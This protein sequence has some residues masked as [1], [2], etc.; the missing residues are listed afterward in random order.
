MLVS[1]R[2]LA[3][4]VDL[5]GITPEQLGN[6]L[7]LSTCEVE[8]IEPFAPHLS[9]V[10]VGHVLE[11]VP[12]PDADKL[13]VCQVDV[14]SGEPLQIVCGAPNVGAGQR[15]AVATIGT[16][17]PGDFKI[18][19]SKIRGVESHGMICSVRELDLGDEHD[20]IWVL[21]EP[22]GEPLALGQSIANALGMGDWVI[23]IDNKSL[24]HRPDLWGHRGLAREVAAIYERPLKPIDLTL[25][26]LG[27]APAF[28]V[29]VA[30]AA[31]SRYIG[32]GIDGVQ[33]GKSPSWMRQLLLAVGQR[34]ID[35]FVDLS[36]FVMLDLGQ[37]NHAFD[38][39]ALDGGGIAVRKAKAG[40]TITTLDGELRKLETSDLL[41][42]SGDAPVA[43]A[44]I[45]GGEESKIQGGTSKLLLECAAFDA[46]TVRRTSSRLALRTDS[47]ARFEKSLDPTLP[48]KAA[49]HFARLLKEIQ[50]GVSFP[51]I[52]SD[53][54]RWSDPATTIHVRGDVVRRDLGVDL[55]DEAIA[56]ILR[57][58]ELTPTAKDGGFEVAIPSARATKDLTMERD[59]VEEVGRIHRYGS[60]PEAPLVGA[61]MPPPFDRRRAM[62][63]AIEDRLAGAARFHQLLSYS[64]Q[65]DDLLSKVNADSG[66]F[67]TAR[68][69]VAPELSKIRREVLPSVLGALETARRRRSEVLVFEV[70][71]G[72]RPE[73]AS[74]DGMP[75]EVHQVVIAIARSKA[76]KGDAGF[77][78]GAF[79]TLR[80]VVDDVV[81]AAGVAVPC[82][83]PGGEAHAT[84]HPV[85]QVIGEWTADGQS[86]GV[87]G[88]LDPAVRGR[89][90]L[91]GELDSDVAVAVLDLDAML[92]APAAP[93][94]YTPLPKFP[95]VKVDVACVAPAE[96]PASAL[97]KAIED[98]G[99]GSVADI[100]LFDVFKGES[101]G[102]GKKSLAYHV[103]LQSANKTL[104]DSDAA[105]FLGRL[106][107]TLEAV[108]AALRR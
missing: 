101:L 50:P 86:A 85:K 89:L 42:T 11:R 75:R 56:D 78:G 96:L 104:T 10:T 62:V 48:E 82:W 80:A 46:A 66:D 68:N 81:R 76:A 58:L 45:M 107:R 21:P 106:E 55:S 26:D 67:V 98:A 40:E 12:H 37:P 49:A 27:G 20:G 79:F 87:I 103:V 13:G 63:R 59:L 74:E 100:E 18:K 52:L 33:N 105:K 97:T 3:R 108:G 31:C 60:V 5:E 102:A 7:T 93:R 19:K 88:E 35:L 53:E 83:S 6:D 4:H 91:V 51:M 84:L 22:D 95:S 43:L 94:T 15:V 65:S 57:R 73:E 39:T 47:S 17:L 70:G 54:G 9:N 71:K 2:W 1:F 72:Y 32:L 38:R 14:G 23:E 25:P 28:P 77:N 16:V 69:P 36:N 34:P 61:V 8:G 24:T 44:G 29:S 90:G 30:D 99:K 41:I 64:F 92:A